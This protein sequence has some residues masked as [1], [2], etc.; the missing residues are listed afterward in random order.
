MFEFWE[1]GHTYHLDDEIIPSVTQIL[2]EWQK[3]KVGGSF[4][5]VN[6]HA[7]AVIDADTFE[8]A[9][10]FG[11]AI[12]KACKLILS[13]DLDWDGIDP[14]LISPLRQFEKAVDDLKLKALWVEVPMHH[15]RKKIAGTPDII[16]NI[17]LTRQL[18]CVDVKTGSYALAGPQT[19][20]YCDIFK[21]YANYKGMMAR[22]VLYLPKDG[23]PYKIIPLKNSKDLAYFDAKLYQFRYLRAA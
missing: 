3:V 23:S 15:K 18:S 13:G 4:W 11:T 12:H 14:D 9:G 8:K 7:G 20:A 5:H 22:F 16:G 2:N 6:T 21:N 17:N 1:D 19:A 10:D